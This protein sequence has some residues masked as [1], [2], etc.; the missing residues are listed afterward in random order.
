M[1]ITRANTSRKV[2]ILTL[3]LALILPSS[4]CSQ[5]DRADWKEQVR[6][7]T[8]QVVTLDRSSVRSKKGSPISS[9]GAIK[10]FAIIFPDSH[11]KWSDDGA[12]RPIAIEIVGESIL[13]AVDIHSRELCARFKN[14]P[15]GVVL[16]KWSGSEWKRIAR[17][18]YPE[19]G[20]L[21]LLLNPWGRTSSDDARGL[22]SLKQK[23]TLS[24]NY[25][26]DAPLD[27]RIGD[28]SHDACEI[29]KNS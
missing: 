22:V 4:A 13:I 14:P 3:L 16:F 23:R 29:Y 7:A 2:A 8:G 18:D 17:S 12:V 10:E 28:K 20:R 26:L 25:Y 5:V 6:L 24:G 15:G 27:R 11:A 19:A 9:R 21:N 1:T